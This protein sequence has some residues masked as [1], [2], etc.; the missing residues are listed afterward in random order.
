MKF[1]TLAI[2]LLYTV[3]NVIEAA[4]AQDKDEAAA[5]RQIEKWQKQYNQYIQDTIKTR[6]S[7]CTKDN[8]VYRQEW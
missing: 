6:D 7:G 5:S 4:P 1:T 3:A 8:I 2:C